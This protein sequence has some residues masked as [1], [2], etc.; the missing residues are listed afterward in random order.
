MYVEYV[1]ALIKYTLLALYKVQKSFITY[2]LMH[3][4]IISLT[5]R[6]FS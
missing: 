3:L 6:D 2:R 4:E 1:I 5:F